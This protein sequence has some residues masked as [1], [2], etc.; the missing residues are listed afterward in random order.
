[1]DMKLE[2][3]VYVEG[4]VDMIVCGGRRQLVMNE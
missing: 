2:I 4:S 3:E 1:M